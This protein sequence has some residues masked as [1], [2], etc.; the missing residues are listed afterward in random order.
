MKRF[1]SPVCLLTGIQYFENIRTQ[2]GRLLT[3]F[4]MKF[5]ST[6]SMWFFIF[7]I[8]FLSLIGLMWIFPVPAA[9]TGMLHPTYSTMLKSGTSVSAVPVSKWLAFFFGI[10]VLG[11]FS[12]LLVIGAQKSSAIINRQINRS[13]LVG[14][15]VYFAMYGLMMLAYWNYEPGGD[16]FLGFPLPTAWMLLG[17]GL[18]P[19][20]FSAL[21]IIKF[22]TWVISQE[23]INRFHE[24]VAARRK[25]EETE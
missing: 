17:L 8:G 22:D 12:F 10:G 5:H 18:M 3:L 23:E 11:T 2:Y 9:A 25:R 20:F 19:L 1:R 7:L 15:V 21:Y 6:I 24:I 14:I 16:F 4:L 13:L